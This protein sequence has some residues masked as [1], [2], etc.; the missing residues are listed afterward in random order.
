MH[1]KIRPALPEEAETLSQIAFTAK[2]HWGYPERWMEIW[3]P[4]LTFDPDYLANN[5][6][7]VAAVNEVPIGFYTLQDKNRNA[8]I[9]NLW[10]SPEYIGKGIGK[11][12]F[13]HA[14]ESSGQRGYHTLQLEADPNAVGFY[15]RMG[16]YRI[17]E[18]H[19][20]VDGERRSLPVL[21]MKLEK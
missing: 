12:L 9:E 6:S 2:A 18:R 3:K 21:E 11:A 7:W 14:V 5:E 4:Q 13:L 15:Q 1:L 10:V 8:W 20:E 19:S 17:G 16:M